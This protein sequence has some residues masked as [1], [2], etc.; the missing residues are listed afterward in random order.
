MVLSNDAE[1]NVKIGLF[2][3]DN[4]FL[5]EMFDIVIKYLK[6]MKKYSSIHEEESGVKRIQIIRS[7]QYSMYKVVH[8]KELIPA[9]LQLIREKDSYNF[10]DEYEKDQFIGDVYECVGEVGK[11]GLIKYNQMLID[12]GFMDIVRN[13]MSESS[14]HSF[15][16]Y[17]TE[18]LWQALAGFLDTPGLMNVD[19]IFDETASNSYLFGNAVK[20]LNTAVA[21]IIKVFRIGTHQQRMRLIEGN[22]QKGERLRSRQ[23]KRVLEALKDIGD[24]EAYEKFPKSGA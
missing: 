20:Y 17:R 16:H 9:L 19:E 13:I 18:G 3:V 11:F 22:I 14:S 5:N 4:G 1:L 15:T 7:M 21:F 24:V 2:L 12:Q 6:N 23:Q 10:K 8:R